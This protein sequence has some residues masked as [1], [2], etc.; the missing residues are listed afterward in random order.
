[1]LF[2]LQKN[3]TKIEEH[4]KTVHGEINHSNVVFAMLISLQKNQTKIEEHIKTVHGKN[5]F[6]CSICNVNFITKES[7]KD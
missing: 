2:S 4:I 6:K 5:P 1:M 3:Q 7:N